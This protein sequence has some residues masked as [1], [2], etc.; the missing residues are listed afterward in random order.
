M[1]SATQS[2]MPHDIGTSFDGPFVDH[3][4]DR[5]P[6]KRARKITSTKSKRH[7]REPRLESM[8][9]YTTA[10]WDELS[11][12]AETEFRAELEAALAAFTRELQRAQRKRAAASQLLVVIPFRWAA[13][14]FGPSTSLWLWRR[15]RF[16]WGRS[17]P[18]RRCRLLR[19]QFGDRAGDLLLAA[20]Q[21][22]HTL[23]QAGERGGHFLELL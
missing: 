3:S 14:D 22:V 6:P 20:G 8:A 18:R 16:R 17:G 5:C 4:E 23:L 9:V 1:L 7:S 2:S 19:N 12:W 13:A 15:Q 21:S 11:A 10:L